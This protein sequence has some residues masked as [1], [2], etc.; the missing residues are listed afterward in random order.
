MSKT[1]GQFGTLQPTANREH[2]QASLPHARPAWNPRQTTHREQ[3]VVSQIH[4]QEEPKEI[5]DDVV[6]CSRQAVKSNM[7]PGYPRR[8]W[9][10]DDIVPTVFQNL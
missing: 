3:E 9:R 1:E 4:Q 8:P 5:G 2:A 6:D 10:C 7:A